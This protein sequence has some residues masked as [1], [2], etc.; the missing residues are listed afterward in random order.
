[1]YFCFL[2]A[3]MPEYVS[4]Q[5]AATRWNALQR[6]A[7]HCRTLQHTLQYTATHWDLLCKA[8]IKTTPATHYGGAAISRLLQIIGLFCKRALW[9][10]LH[11]VK[12]TD[13]FKEPT[14]RSHRI[15]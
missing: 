10:K 12:E 13:Y 5:R 1:M 6:A 7:T 14:N 2:Q 11:S 3:D 4:L 8:F 15:E 9:K